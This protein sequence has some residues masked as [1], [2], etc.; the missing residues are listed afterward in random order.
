MLKINK[1]NVL[2]VS[3]AKPGGLVVV[4]SNPATPTNLSNPTALGGNE[5]PLNFRGFFFL[6]VD[7]ALAPCRHVWRKIRHNSLSVLCPC[8]LLDCQVHTMIF[9]FSFRSTSYVWSWE[10]GFMGSMPTQLAI[11]RDH[12]MRWPAACVEL[13]SRTVDRAAAISWVDKRDDVHRIRATS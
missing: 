3:S 8:G 6:A 13:Q 4:G 9:I 12:A 7:S 10:S 5:D 11:Q 1:I 2:C